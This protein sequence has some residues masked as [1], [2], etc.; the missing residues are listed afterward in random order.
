VKL[1]RKQIRKMIVEAM[2]INPMTGLPRTEADVVPEPTKDDFMI[3]AHAIGNILHGTGHSDENYRDYMGAKYAVMSYFENL[4]KYGD[5][6]RMPGKYADKVDNMSPRILNTIKELGL[7]LR[8]PRQIEAL[9]A[10]VMN[11]IRSRES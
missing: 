10:E 4:L 2:N 9:A 1:S 3:A 5:R 11:N 7:T 6:V 8:A